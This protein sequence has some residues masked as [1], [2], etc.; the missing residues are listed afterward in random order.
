MSIFP[1]SEAS[2]SAKVQEYY[3][4]GQKPLSVQQVQSTIAKHPLLRPP[5]HVFILNGVIDVPHGTAVGYTPYGEKVIVLTPLSN[6]ET[7][8]HEMIHESTGLGELPTQILTAI[9]I[10]KEPFTVFKSPIQYED[11]GRVGPC[12]STQRILQQLHL[13]PVTGRAGVEHIVLLDKM[14]QLSPMIP[15]G[16]TH[17]VLAA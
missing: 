9:L 6:E 1:G 11:C 15:G 7:V 8:L 10:R 17:Y 16:L 5:D 4:R 14:F 13:Q 2:P 12:Q 3:A